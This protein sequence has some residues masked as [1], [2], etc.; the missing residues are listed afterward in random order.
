MRYICFRLPLAIIFCLILLIQANPASAYYFPFG[1][2]YYGAGN[3]LLYPLSM[4]AYPYSYSSYGSPLYGLGY[5]G[6]L[7]LGSAAYSAYRYL[8]YNGLYNY[9]Y[10]N[11]YVTGAYGYSP[12]TS[13]NYPFNY[14]QTANNA[15]DIFNYQSPPV[16][17]DRRFLG[18]QPTDQSQLNNLSFG[19]DAGALNGFF[20]TINNRYHSDLV[21]A[22]RQP[23]IRSWAQSIGLIDANY[24]ASPILNKSRKGEI[25]NTLKD[26]SLDPQTKLQLLRLFLR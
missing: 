1:F 2:G 11:N 3:S 18:R 8:P 25:S 22:L 13:T 15:N 16:A 6:S 21:H 24:V 19:Q 14:S 7:G 5:L 10:T 26:N 4:L 12:N 17:P 23:D 9:P 20:Q